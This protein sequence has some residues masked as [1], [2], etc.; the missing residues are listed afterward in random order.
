MDSQMSVTIDWEYNDRTYIMEARSKDDSVYKALNLKG[1]YIDIGANVG[2][3]SVF[4]A[5]QCPCTHIVAVEP[6]SAFFS[7]FERNMARNAPNCT[8][9]A[10]QTPLLSHNGFGSM[11]TSDV[12]EAENSWAV[13]DNTGVM[14][15]TTL[16]SIG[17]SEAALLKIDVEGSESEVIRGAT[18]TLTN[19]QPVIV[20]ELVTDGKYDEF[21]RLVAPMNY[22]S[23]HTNLYPQGAPTY[24]FRRV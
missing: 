5:T 4:F 14:P 15:I 20:V 1:T 11:Q 22:T 12:H 9:K 10:I 8:Y 19:L 18:K 7:C 2:N 24:L 3:H 6:V 17:I 23:D 16:D 13:Y 21:E